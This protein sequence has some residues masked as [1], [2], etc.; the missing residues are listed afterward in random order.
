MIKKVFAFNEKGEKKE[1]AVTKFLMITDNDSQLEISL[2]VPYH[3]EQ[4]DFSIQVETGPI[5]EMP[6]H[7]GKFEAIEGH[8][9]LSVLPGANNLLFIKINRKIKIE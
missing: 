2:D 3:P 5:K 7:P 8:R 6:S 1:L 4:P 9:Y